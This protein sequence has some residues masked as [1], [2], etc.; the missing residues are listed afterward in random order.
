MGF[1][2]RYWWF[3][4]VENQGRRGEFVVSDEDLRVESEDCEAPLVIENGWRVR[5]LVQREEEMRSV[6]DVQAEAFYSPMAFFNGFFFEIFKAEVL[7]GLLYRIRNSAPNRYACLVAETDNKP[8]SQ[9]VTYPRIIGVVDVTVL[10]DDSVLQFLDDAD[11]YL[12]VSGIAVLTAF[13]RRKVATVLLKACDLVAMLWKF[14]YLVL[15]AYE[16]D[17][18]ARKLYSTAGYR[19]VAKD[20]LWMTS[21]IG[22]RRRVLMIKKT[23]P[24]QELN[25]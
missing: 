16:D 14:D 9:A 5:S 11:E 2:T 13:R 6:A 1:I 19:V 25:P 18:G 12:Y 22:R 15:R 24:D 21:W 10:R 4:E 8:E 23:P 20:P 17:V 7:A 3:T